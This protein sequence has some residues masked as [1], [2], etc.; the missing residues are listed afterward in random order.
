MNNLTIKSQEAIQQA[1]TYAQGYG[2]Q[3]VEPIHLLKGVLSQAEN[4]TSYIFKKVGVNPTT[5]DSAITRV[6][7]SYP[8]VSGGEQYLTQASKSVLQKATNS[9]QN[10]KDQFVSVEHILLAII[11]SDDQAAQIMKDAGM[12]HNGLL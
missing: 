5:F 8:R 9:A 3:A 12:S 1:V 4:L 7:E 10:L 11:D 6:L 2:H